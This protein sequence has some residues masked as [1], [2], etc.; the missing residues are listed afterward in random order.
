MQRLTVI[1]TVAS[2]DP[3]GVVEFLAEASGLSR[4]RIKDAMKKGAL[5]RT[6]KGGK[7]TR[8]RKAT[9][10]LH[11]GDRIEFYYDE[12]LL[13]TIPPQA[14]LVH[15][16]GHYSVWNKPAGLLTQGTR[17]GDHCALLRQAEQYFVPRR[18]VYPVH[19]L[20]REASGLVL[21][22]HSSRAATKLSELFR[23]GQVDKIYRAEVRGNLMETKPEGIIDTPL[24]GKE[25]RTEYRVL[26]YRED[27]DTTIVEVRIGT[28][29]FHQIRR[30]FDGI[31]FPVMGDPRYGKGNKNTDGLKLSATEL[32]FTC[33]FN[34]RA[35]EF[36][37][38]IAHK[39]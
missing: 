4:M 27:T 23:Q 36:S 19:R 5:R 32:R 35:M 6:R 16:E 11:P 12:A 3:K 21:I 33:P 25:A 31:G 24:E 20:D 29:R 2:G 17:Y 13:A 18:E 7:A 14:A 26:R 9:A 39:L 1:K 22:A 28:G 8:L 34:N 38:Q 30:H 37:S 10:S 15:D